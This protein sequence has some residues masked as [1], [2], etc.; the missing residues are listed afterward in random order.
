MKLLLDQNISW[1]LVENLQEAF[2]GTGHVKT[3]LSTDA[4]DRAI[5]KFAKANDFAV[6]TKDDDFEQRSVLNG[7]P[8]KVIWIRNPTARSIRVSR[9]SGKSEEKL[10]NRRRDIDCD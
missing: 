2:P 9:H 6:V 5:W 3:L 1:K 10:R 7:H 8:P 4:S